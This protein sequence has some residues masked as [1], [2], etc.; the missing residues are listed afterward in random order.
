MYK[1]H[2]FE[3]RS[4]FLIAVEDP[5]PIT[6]LLNVSQCQIVEKS[7]RKK[8]E[9]ATGEFTEPLHNSVQ[10]RFSLSG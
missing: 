5:S 8:A 9:K 4:L 7:L 10:E 2:V 3:H 1:V 6:R